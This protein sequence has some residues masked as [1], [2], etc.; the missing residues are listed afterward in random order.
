MRLQASACN[1][2]ENDC[3]VRD[4]GFRSRAI[5]F[6]KKDEAWNFQ[7]PACIEGDKVLGTTAI[8]RQ[9]GVA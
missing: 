4:D 2:S 8:K 7:T 6:L 3:A 5:K 1:P 9:L